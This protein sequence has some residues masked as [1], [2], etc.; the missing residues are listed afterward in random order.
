MR[1]IL[2]LLAFF[3]LFLSAQVEQIGILNN[4]LVVEDDS[5][6]TV[7]GYL[8]EAEKIHLFAFFG[9]SSVTFAYA[10][11]DTWYHVTNAS[12]SLWRYSEKDGFTVEND[13]ITITEAGDYDLSCSMSFEGGNGQT[14]AFRFFNVTGTA[15]VPVA[16][17]NTAGGAGN[18]VNVKVSAY[19]QNATAGTKIVLQGKSD[20]TTSTTLKNSAIKI[21]KVHE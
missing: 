21:Y 8:R 7:N 6:V 14:Y 1:K 13:T 9:D 2:F 10:S 16:N 19:L 3:P 12:D 15:G 18:V 20:G 11:S 17:A 4:A 5:N